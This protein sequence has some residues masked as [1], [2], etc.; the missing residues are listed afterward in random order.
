MKDERKTKKQLIEE[1]QQLRSRAEAH[2]LKQSREREALRNRAVQQTALSLFTHEALMGTGQ[3]T[4]MQQACTLVA[5]TL[6]VEYCKVLELGPEGDHLV[7]LAGIGWREGLV[8]TAR[9]GTE[10]ESQAGFTMLSDEPVVVRDLK[11]ETRFSGPAL[12][13]EHNVRSGISV[14]IAGSERPFG[15]FGAHSTRA[16][17]FSSDE[18]TFVQAVANVLAQYIIKQ[19]TE[20]R[21]QKS[22]EQL[23][24]LI[25]ATPDIVCFKDAEGR[26]LEANRAERELFQ[27]DENIYQGKTNAEL[28]CIRPAFKNALLDCAAGDEKAWQTSSTLHFEQHVIDAQGEEKIFDI[29]KV[30]LFSSIGE[31]RGLVVLGR[32]ITQRKQAEGELISYKKH[33][34]EQ[35]QQRTASLRET[36]RLLEAE[37]KERRLI[38]RTVRSSGEFLQATLDAIPANIAILD[39]TGTIISVN[40]AWRAFADENNG[41]ETSCGVGTNYLVICESA[42]G[43]GTQDARRVARG[44]R[45]LLGRHRDDYHTEYPCHS[46]SFQRWFGLDIRRFVS[47][48]QDRLVVVHQN[49]TERKLAEI[50]VEKERSRLFSLLDEMPATVCLLDRSYRYRFTNRRFREKLGDPGSR[51]CYGII[52]GE[53]SPCGNCPLSDVLDTRQPRMMEEQRA[54]ERTYQLYYYPFIDVDGTFLALELGI[55]ITDRTRAEAA[56]SREA[57]INAAMAELARAII[58]A[59]SI[60]AISQLVLDTAQQLTESTVGFVG[61]IDTNTGYMVAPTMTRHVWD[62]CRVPHKDVVFEKFGGLWGWVLQHQQPLLSNSPAD[63]DRSSGV[64]EGHIPVSRFLSVPAMTEDTLVGQIALA[65]APRQYTDGDLQLVERLA[66]LYAIAVYRIQSQRELV[67]AKEAAEAANRAKSEFLATMSHELR[68]PLNSIIGFSEILADGP[69]GPL[70]DK[71][72]RYAENILSSGRHLLS[73]IN[74]IL[75]LSKIESGRTDL[76]LSPVSVDSLLEDSLLLIKEKT[77]RHNIALTLTVAPDTQSLTVVADEQ[78]LKQVLFNILSNAA[79]FTPEGGAI[80]VVARRTVI[81]EGHKDDGGSAS[82]GRDAVEFSVQDTGVGIDPKD[83]ERIFMEFQQLDSSYSR[84]HQGTGLGLALV[85]R[86]VE[87]HGGTIRVE[88]EGKNCGSTFIFDI[89]VLQQ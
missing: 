60:D 10:K 77:M 66:T 27:L 48:E 43:E 33:L 65:N 26:W 75:D 40:A 30:P 53:S 25:E 41:A 85:K 1:L 21:L 68:T 73:L 16:R 54:G 12:L 6:G 46:E 29:I 80:A 32:D 38:E 11:T 23:R 57:Q 34:E 36:N 14:I 18:V 9:V 52:C 35:V 13:C 31:R 71:Q 74:D 62:R 86:L 72:Q 58:S 24:T 70:N 50:A 64:P 15:V 8:G 44:I 17:D 39:E 22:E 45:E 78:K 56:R 89:P 76:D 5:Q 59:Q 81:P 2:D 28:A 67:V 88:S 79:K 51:T 63:D 37:I 69:F 47:M 3:Q 19:E 4:L 55:D 87:M 82:A 42:Q 61:Y 7:L 49:I 20:S 83:C 84:V